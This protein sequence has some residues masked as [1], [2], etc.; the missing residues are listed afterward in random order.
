MINNELKDAR[1]KLGLSQAGLGEALHLTRVMIGLMERGENP[2][3]KRTELAVWCLLYE[4]G[5]AAIGDRATKNG[6]L[7]DT[8]LFWGEST[9]AA[10]SRNYSS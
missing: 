6:L 9:L 8:G 7:D 5:F 3:E 1:Q 2:I 10:V 4:G